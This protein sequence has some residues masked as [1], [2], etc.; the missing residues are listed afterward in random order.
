MSRG[1]AFVLHWKR[2]QPRQ[3]GWH[4][5]R[6]SG[7]SRLVVP[8]RLRFRCRFTPC[9]DPLRPGY[10]DRRSLPHPAERSI[11]SIGLRSTALHSNP[12]QG[13]RLITVLG[14]IITDTLN[15]IW[16]VWVLFPS[17]AG[18]DLHFRRLSTSTDPIDDWDPE[19]TTGYGQ[20]PV[21]ED[22]KDEEPSDQCS[23]MS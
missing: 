19:S 17:L 21:I 7:T 15:A 8:R 22:L 4:Q 20:P 3:T 9:P 2:T 11:L 5:I 16:E 1:P 6:F 18:F 13:Y 10:S 12:G 14:W 23:F